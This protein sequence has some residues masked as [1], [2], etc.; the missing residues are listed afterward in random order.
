MTNVG[1]LLLAAGKGSR[2][3]DLRHGRP[4]PLM[5][6]AGRT[7]LE[8]NLE[9]I[10]AH[11]VRTTWVNLHEGADQIRQTIGGEA[12]GVHVRYSF[13]PELLGT[14]GGWRNLADEW[15]TTSLVVYGDNVTR[16]DLRAF[17]AAH[18]AGRAPA[19]IAL[20]DP[21][22]HQNTG[23]AGGWAHVNE[24][25]MVTDFVEGAR[26]DASAYVNAGVYL[27]EP[28]VLA[29]VQ[30]DTPDFGRDVLPKLAERGDVQGYLME[31]SGFCLGVDTPERFAI[32]ERML[33]AG[34]VQP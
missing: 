28:E 20:F 33:A 6:L 4:K 5:P 14:A 27:L 23:I 24:E 16:F 22:V 3:S 11:G 17:H 32:A 8:W 19:T 30:G 15:T 29:D 1:A 9:W 7:L 25:W 10:G 31:A 21:S 13:E 12:R 34:S 18:V 2:L 26:P